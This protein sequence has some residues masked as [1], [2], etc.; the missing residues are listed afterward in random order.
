M[1]QHFKNHG[2]EVIGMGKIFDPRSVD[3]RNTM[4]TASWSRPYVRVTSVAHA[5]FG[6]RDPETVRLITAGRTASHSDGVGGWREAQA[7]I[8]LKPPTDSADVPDEAYDD[9]ALAVAGV[10]HIQELAASGNPFFL[11]VGLKKVVAGG[12]QAPP[13]R[14]KK[15]VHICVHSKAA[16]TSSDSRQTVLVGDEGLEPPT[17]SV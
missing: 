9:G 12:G 15:S 5:T 13:D 1:P 11:A 2:Y 10:R 17:P 3:G 6:Y 8:G 7:A 16:A 14:A 4:D